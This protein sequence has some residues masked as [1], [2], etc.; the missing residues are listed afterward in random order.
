MRPQGP[1]VALL[2]L[3]MAAAGCRPAVAPPTAAPPDIRGTITRIEAR[4][5]GDVL[6]RVLIEGKL[7]PD[8]Q[9]D[10]AFVDVPAEARI[11][12][13]GGQVAGSATFADLEA[14]Q[15]VEARFTGPVRESYPV[16]ATCPHAAAGRRPVHRPAGRC[17]QS[18]WLSA[19]CRAAAAGR[20]RSPLHLAAQRGHGPGHDLQWGT[21]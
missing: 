12:V 18:L 3:S 7:E 13:Q 17:R 4:Q 20:G 11:L 2:V 10:K 1:L 16:Q 21:R 5:G 6:G 9:Y 15:L 19:L 14:G 8:T